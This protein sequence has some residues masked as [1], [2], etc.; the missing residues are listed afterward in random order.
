MKAFG[1]AIAGF[2]ILVAPG[3]ADAADLTKIERTIAKEPAYKSKPK[4]CLLVFGPEAKTRVWLV[5]D[6]DVLYV[7]RNGNGD[8]TDAREK[9]DGPVGAAPYFRA[10]DIIEA[11]GTTKHRDLGVQFHDKDGWTL[12]FV[13]VQGK[14]QQMA[15]LGQRCLQFA[16]RPQD[17]PFVH[18]N[19]PLTLNLVEHPTCD[20]QRRDSFFVE[21]GTP[22]LGKG[23]FAAIETFNTRGGF[24]ASWPRETVIFQD[25][26]PWAEIECERKAPG[27]KPIKAKI[28]LNR[29]EH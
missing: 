14:G 26:H 21:I 27:G 25:I 20:P 6:G 23:T 18:F 11:D 3:L 1:F 15:S 12:V 22:G 2:V 9:V 8:L 24:P 19:G 7:D 16:D 10:G 28:A 5:R 29:R 13:T 4:Y 17:A